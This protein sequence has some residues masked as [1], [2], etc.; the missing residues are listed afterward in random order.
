MSR[1]LAI[2]RSIKTRVVSQIFGDHKRI[3]IFNVG[4]EDDVKFPKTLTFVVTSPNF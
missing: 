3:S 2:T 1:I 4:I